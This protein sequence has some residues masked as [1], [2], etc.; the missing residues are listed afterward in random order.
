MGPFDLLRPEPAPRFGHPPARNAYVELHNL[1]AAAASIQDFGVDDLLRISR[2]HDVDLRTTFY[3]ERLALYQG[4][5]DDRLANGDLDA[6]DRAVLAHVARA[7]HLSAADLRPAHERAFGKA[8][9]EAISDDCLSVEERLLLYKL[10]HLLGL[11]PRLADG[12]YEVMA[13]ER[14]LL[15][16]ARTLCDGELSPEEAAEVEHV[17]AELDVEMPERV[18]AM[19]GEAAARWEVRHGEMPTVSVGIR[20]EPGETGHY[21]ARDARWQNV[22]SARLGQVV[23]KERLRTGQ[24]DG[25]RVPQA[26]LFA[27]TDVGQAIVTSRR[28]VLVPA[29]GLTDEYPYRSLVQTLRF[30]NGT[31][32]RTKGDRRVYIDAGNDHRPFYTVLYRAMR[33]SRDLPPD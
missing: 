29:Q 2:R 13:R 8:V 14:L 22:N 20:L 16:V 21:V 3:P 28:L 12:A 19:L 5:L 26:A 27:R 6:D 15:T 9:T 32:I 23:P 24:T 25:L 10:Q 31:V 17:R 18:A 7:L 30:A 1:I 33:P 11:D 4:L